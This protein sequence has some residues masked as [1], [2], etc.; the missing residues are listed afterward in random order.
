M[1]K[2][3]RSQQEKTEQAFYAVG[4]SFLGV[5]LMLYLLYKM[6]PISLGRFLM[7]R[8]FLKLTGL[9]CPG[10]GGT[11]AVAALL[12]GK[13]LLSF[14]YHPIVPYAAAI[15]LW[16]MATHSIQRISRGK[17]RAGMRYRD[18]Y[19]WIALGLVAVN[20]F[21]KNGILL[22]FHQDILKLLGHYW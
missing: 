7:P 9:Y 2:I 11:R 6:F 14:F 16:Y 3:N 17:I 10:C 4:A 12:K 19:L 20:F 1:S 21:I 18:A 15:Y 5:V 8:M 13:W 22:V